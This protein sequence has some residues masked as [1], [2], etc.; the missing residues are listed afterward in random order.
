MPTITL[1]RAWN[2][3]AEHHAPGD[4][5]DVDDDVAAWLTRTGAVARPTRK[6]KAAPAVEPSE[7]ESAAEAPAVEPSE[8]D[9]DEDK[10]PARTASLDTWKAFA[11]K[12][13][14]Q[15][16]GMSKQDIIAATA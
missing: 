9:G 3:G 14:I 13:G 11:E 7:D 10:R 1:A 2:P 16:K 5:V 6:R 15:T 8:D 12:Q 4:E